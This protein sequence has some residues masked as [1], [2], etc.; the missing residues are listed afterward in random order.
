MDFDGLLVFRRKDLCEAK[1]ETESVFKFSDV[2]F[3]LRSDVPPSVEALVAKCGTKLGPVD[4]S[5]DV[6]QVEASGGQEWY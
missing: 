6:P 2:L 1:H 4:L 5:L 3:A